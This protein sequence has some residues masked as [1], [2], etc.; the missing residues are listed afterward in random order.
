MIWSDFENLA[1]CSSI[2]WRTLHSSSFVYV[3]LGYYIHRQYKCYFY[4]SRNFSQ[5]WSRVYFHLIYQIQILLCWVHCRSKLE[6]HPD[7]RP[8]F[9]LLF[10]KTKLHKYSLRCIKL[11]M[12]FLCNHV[13]HKNRMSYLFISPLKAS[14]DI[15]SSE[16]QF[17]FQNPIF[18]PDSI[19]IL[20]SGLMVFY[21][22]KIS[23]EESSK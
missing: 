10:L 19:W 13:S 2:S 3:E 20:S 22:N 7:G 15:F 4:Y 18:G 14:S 23:N 5:F 16:R 12:F 8:F 6:A 17:M 1:N 9:L 21:K 11:F